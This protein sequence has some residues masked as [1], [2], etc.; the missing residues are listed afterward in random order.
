[1]ALGRVTTIT[2]PPNADVYDYGEGDV[3]VTYGNSEEMVARRSAS[4]WTKIHPVFAL[5]QLLA[6]F[7]SLGLL[8]GYFRG[9]VSFD[10]VHQSVLVKVALMVG[11]IITGALWE[12]DVF[13]AYWFAPE[14][15]AEDTMTVNVFILHASYLLMAVAHPENVSLL[16]GML[17]VA[18]GVYVA[19]V[20]Q[21]V[22]RT[23]VLGKHVAVRVR[24]R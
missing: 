9:A 11:A 5:G 6:F 16:I 19:N 1:L 10:V 23:A 22:V 20:A 14:F 4:V 13:G 3:Q 21:Y 12:K 7:V 8:I 18:Y 2:V 24:S 15:M 17:I